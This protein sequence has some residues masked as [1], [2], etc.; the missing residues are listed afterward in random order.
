MKLRKST[1]TRVLSG[2]VAGVML[3]STVVTVGAANVTFTDTGS[4]WAKNQINYLVS[5]DVL[6]GYKQSNG[7][8]IFKPDGTVTRAEFIKMLDE[9]FGL[10]ATIGISYSDV[11]T[12]DWFHSYFSKAAA[13]GYLLNYGTSVNPNGQ[14]TREEATTLLVRYLGIQD[15]Q[16]SPASTFVDY[17]Q[18]SS[19]FQG[20]V[21]AAV[22]AGLINGY[23]EKGGTY[24]KPKGTLTR[25][26]ALTI[27]YRAAGAIYKTSAY[28]KDSGAPDTNTTITKGDIT[29]S[30]MILGGRV[31]ITEGASGGTVTLTG[32]TITGN[33]EIRGAANLTI[34]NCTVA[35]AVLESIAPSINISL[36]G[37]TTITSLELLTTATMSISSGCKVNSMLV[38]EE[39]KNIKI[40]GDGTIE[41]LYVNASGFVSTMMPQEFNISAGLTANFASQ[42][43]TGSSEDQ[44]SFVN[45]PYMTEEGGKY[46]LHVTAESTGRVYWYYTRQSYTPSADEFMSAYSAANAKGSFNVQANVTTSNATESANTAKDY[47]HVVIQLSAGDRSYAPIVI[48][49]TATSGTGFY[50]DPYY[51]GREIAFQPDIDGTLYY[52]YT[53]E[54]DTVTAD[55]FNRN[56]RNTESSLRGSATVSDGR[57]NSISLNER[58]LDSYPFV[59]VALEGKNGQYYIPVVV[60]AGDNG[61]AEDPVITTMGE[62]E[63]TADINGTLYY[64]Y[65]KD[66][67]M[68]TPQYVA[69]Y[70]RTE[71]DYNYVSVSRNKR[72]TLDY[73]TETAEL[74]PYMVLC[75]KDSGGNFLT[76]V[77]LKIDMDT[78]FSVQPYVSGNDEITFRAEHVGTVY[79]YF[80]RYNT[81]PSTTE[82]MDEWR[83][84]P[85]RQCGTASVN[86]YNSYS[87]FTF[88]S[89]YVGSYPYIAIMLVDADEV[90][91][92]PV[93]ID[94]K[95]TTTT[96]FTVDPYCDLAAKRVY[97]YPSGDGEV[98]YYFTPATSAFS[99]TSEE[100]WD[101][102]GDHDEIGYEIA[103]K[104]LGYVDFAS[105]VNK[106]GSYYKGI[107]L[108]YVD[109]DNRD[110]YP[111]YV[112]LM[113]DTSVG[114]SSTG[115]T[116][117]S[118]TETKVTLYAHVSGL[119][120]Y[121][122]RGSGSRWSSGSKTVSRGETFSISVDTS[123][124]DTMIIEMEGYDDFTIDLEEEYDR[125]E[126]TGDGSN[127]EGSGLLSVDYDAGSY[128]ISGIPTES[129]TLYIRIGGVRDSEGLLNNTFTKSV[130]KN[131]RFDFTFDADTQAYLDILDNFIGVGNISLAS[132]SVQLITKDGSIY[133]EVIVS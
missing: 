57:N 9:T 79:W 47:S 81:M 49:N 83:S 132:V 19:H 21:M 46:M 50:V 96:G 84:T 44:A 116:L 93:V 64:Y 121:S 71:K 54:G 117:M 89:D 13:Q 69:N 7:T 106:Y 82:F 127:K 107:M 35:S 73:D 18:I 25:A 129:G 74:Y 22:Y 15:G 8:Y 113:R 63:F 77:L 23:N 109:D 12:S 24:F 14:L 131:T 37:G 105:I 27:L 17:N 133:E 100:F 86:S 51:T 26:E 36:T 80:T 102:Y 118:V 48:E 2:V 111:V 4:H 101:S 30:G 39:A 98:Y 94:V 16:K 99:E 20:P 31:I 108:M 61:F 97:F 120:E 75:I 115:L 32:C 95:N 70:W 122:V 124:Y 72:D 42:P 58:Y 40:T 33:L 59:V 3:L 87:Y 34:N 55:E 130:T 60:A 110:H 67:T 56:Y 1:L 78:G 10:T 104:S 6:N 128:T 52:Y 38:G 41:A 119:V 90:L 43:Y 62:I 85:T 5:K 53:D 125:D 123:R 112:S 92:Q 66:D 88:D 29:V 103:N 91:Y 76:P 65:T 45:V 126:T 114:T 11:K 28:S 68:P